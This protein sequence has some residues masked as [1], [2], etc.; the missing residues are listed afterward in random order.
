MWMGNRKYYPEKRFESLDD[1]DDEKEDQTQNSES[2]DE[3]EHLSEFEMST[4]SSDVI[5]IRNFPML[6]LCIFVICFL[7]L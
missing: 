7:L 6:Q 3:W 2:N 1:E 5:S 4:N